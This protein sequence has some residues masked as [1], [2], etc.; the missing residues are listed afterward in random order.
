MGSRHSIALSAIAGAALFGGAL[1]IGSPTATAALE[2]FWP[3]GE[4]GSTPYWWRGWPVTTTNANDTDFLGLVGFSTGDVVYAYDNYGTEPWYEASQY[5]FTMPLVFDF[6]GIK[7]TDV[8]DASHGYPSVG[9]TYDAFQALMV[10]Y[11]V[12]GTVPVWQTATLDDPE[13]G[14]LNYWGLGSSF[15]VIVSNALLSTDAGMKDVVTVFGQ[16]FVLFDTSSDSAGAGA[17]ADTGFDQLLQE[18]TF[19][20][21]AA[22]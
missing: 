13:L 8:P 2:D 4:L 9:T 1:T 22:G 7:V 20:A 10:P 14:T 3:Y 16:G 21:P 17:A 15:G 11:G 18:L 6:S 12:G 19:M 5:E